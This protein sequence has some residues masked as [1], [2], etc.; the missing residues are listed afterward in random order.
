MIVKYKRIIL[1][2][3]VFVCMTCFCSAFLSSNIAQA[4]SLNQKKTFNI[5]MKKGT[6]STSKAQTKAVQE[7][8]KYLGLYN[9]SVDGSYGPN[10]K[11][12]VKKF[13]SRNGLT[14]D[15]SAGPATTAK[16]RKSTSISGKTASY[17]HHLFRAYPKYY[18]Y[19]GTS[20]TGP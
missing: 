9:D 15:G 13:Q 8:L 11:A 1:L 4:Y 14:A 6:A 20:S 7:R 17:G 3:V 5:E 16:L 18:I 2:T 10:T 12:A 19:L